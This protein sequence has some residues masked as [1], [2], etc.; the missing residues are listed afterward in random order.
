MSSPCIEWTG[1][2]D[3][4][5]YGRVQAGGRSV[6]A[7]RLAYVRANGLFLDDIKGLVVMHKCDNPCCHNPD[8]LLLGTKGDNNRDRAAKGRNAISERRKLSNQEAEAIRAAYI[9]NNRDHSQRA[10]A[11]RYGVTQRVVLRIVKGV[12]YK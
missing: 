3:D 11:K 6:G 1:R 8:H 12:N 4:C 7:H 5:G 2:R 10:L 9:P